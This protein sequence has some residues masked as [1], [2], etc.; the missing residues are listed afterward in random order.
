MQSNNLWLH[1]LRKAVLVFMIGWSGLSVAYDQET[2]ASAATAYDEGVR[3]FENKDWWNAATKLK[4]SHDLLPFPITAYYVSVACAKMAYSSGALEYVKKA[5][6][7][8]PPLEPQL[9]NQH[10]LRQPYLDEANK[11]LAWAE[12]HDRIVKIEGRA[13]SFFPKPPPPTNLSSVPGSFPI[14]V[15]KVSPP[16]V[17][18]G[19]KPPSPA[20]GPQIVV[21]SPG[22]LLHRD[23][24][25]T[26]RGD[27]GGTYVI[28][29]VGQEIWW[30]GRS[31]DGGTSWAN[32]FHG[33]LHQGKIVGEWADVPMGK[34]RN[35][36]KLVL[37]LQNPREFKAIRKT[38][39]FGGNVWRR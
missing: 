30:F 14:T 20:N 34:A 35:S 5:L 27:D 19:I 7:G 4:E 25:G 1:F 38:G 10:R 21:A 6:N 2:V 9:V 31:R 15:P 28:R 12:E 26:W 36:G 13:D 32:V 16:A 29:Q 22:V 24:T 3:L 23:L 39:G 8:D 33:K 37:E 18:G 11:I 17:K